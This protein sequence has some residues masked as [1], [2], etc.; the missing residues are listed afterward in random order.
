MIAAAQTTVHGFSS[1]CF[2]TT[3]LRHSRHLP[4]FQRKLESRTPG[5]SQ[6]TA[7]LTSPETP[8]ERVPRPG[9]IVSR[10]ASTSDRGMS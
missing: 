8:Y 1:I 3:Y 4:S 9:I 7:N 6:D 2:L 5:E 10:K